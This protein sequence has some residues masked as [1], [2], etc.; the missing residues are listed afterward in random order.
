[1]P[2]TPSG[3]GDLELFDVRARGSTIDLTAANSGRGQLVL[4]VHRIACPTANGRRTIEPGRRL[5]LAPG[6]RDTI[7][8]DL[9]MAI[10]DGPLRCWYSYGSPVDPDRFSARLDAELRAG[11]GRPT[12]RSTLDL[13]AFGL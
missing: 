3:P 12:R 10:D 9:S 1:M 8:I 11:R 7:S 2:G 5:A 13:W 6:D 4:M